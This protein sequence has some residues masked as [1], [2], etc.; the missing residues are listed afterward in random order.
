[1]NTWDE[2]KIDNWKKCLKV[3]TTD[4]LFEAVGQLA[5]KHNWPLGDKDPL[6]IVIDDYYYCLGDPS[7]TLTEMVEAKTTKH[8]IVWGPE[9]ENDYEQVQLDG[10]IYWVNV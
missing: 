9:K 10:K 2:K 7:S 3:E 5:I 1:M 6:G 8:E 4:E